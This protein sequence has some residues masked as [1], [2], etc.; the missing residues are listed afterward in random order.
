MDWR[1]RYRHRPEQEPTAKVSALVGYLITVE[2]EVILVAFVDLSDTRFL[3]EP[4]ALFGTLPV[5][6]VEAP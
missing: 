2:I 1:R 6:E 3:T 4:A 5:G